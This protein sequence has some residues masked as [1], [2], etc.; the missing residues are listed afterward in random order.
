[1]PLLIAG[2]LQAI[3]INSS[4]A[5]FI[6]A[7]VLTSEQ[8]SALDFFQT[9]LEFLINTAVLLIQLVFMDW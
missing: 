5:P 9:L 6:M 2:P 7:P 1:M 3:D 8:S 4:I